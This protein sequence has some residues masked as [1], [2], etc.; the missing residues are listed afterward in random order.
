[1]RPS[2]TFPP[3]KELLPIIEDQENK[4]Q[5]VA[6]EN[7][8]GYKNGREKEQPQP[9]RMDIGTQ[10]RSLHTAGIQTPLRRVWPS[11]AGREAIETCLGLPSRCWR[12]LCTQRGLSLETSAMKSTDRSGHWGKLQTSGACLPRHTPEG[13]ETIPSA[14]WL[15]TS[16]LIKFHTF[17]QQSQHDVW[18][19][20]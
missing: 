8:K 2:L 1:V 6:T 13:K 4:S 20:S 7:S 19:W 16:M 15:Q 14:V 12:K 11:I 17:Q 18:M 3:Q 10:G 5:L 9:P